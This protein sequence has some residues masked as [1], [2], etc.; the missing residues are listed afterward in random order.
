MGRHRAEEVGVNVCIVHIVSF[1][2]YNRVYFVII[3]E[4]QQQQQQRQRRQPQQAAVALSTYSSTRHSSYIA[5]CSCD[6]LTG[7]VAAARAVVAT[8]AW[9]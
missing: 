5:S 6:M 4:Q 9:V 2:T 8:G 3:M 7:P 1:S